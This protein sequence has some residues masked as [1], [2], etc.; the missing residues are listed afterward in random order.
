V[1][2]CS[3]YGQAEVKRFD[4][5]EKRGKEAQHGQEGGRYPPVLVFPGGTPMMENNRYI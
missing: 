5:A 2:Y 4:G 1:A 3:I